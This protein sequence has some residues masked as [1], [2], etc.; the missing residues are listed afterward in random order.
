MA[1]SVFD[2]VGIAEKCL[3]PRCTFFINPSHINEPSAYFAQFL[4]GVNVS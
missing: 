2:P 4:S 1:K 3:Y